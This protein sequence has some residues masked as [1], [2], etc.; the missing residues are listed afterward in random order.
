MS[1]IFCSF[2]NLNEIIGLRRPNLIRFCGNEIKEYLVGRNNIK[3][4]Q[5]QETIEGEGRR[6]VIPCQKKSE[7]PISFQLTLAK[8]YVTSKQ[9]RLVILLVTLKYFN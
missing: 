4:M 5:S 9:T 8:K 2:S 7:N 1:D 6:N 3:Q